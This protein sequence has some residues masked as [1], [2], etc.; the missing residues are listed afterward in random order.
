VAAATGRR[1]GCA[2]DYN[3]TRDRAH[4]VQ[5]G[6]T[7]DGRAC[8]TVVQCSRA[9]GIVANMSTG[10]SSRRSLGRNSGLCCRAGNGA[11]FG[12]G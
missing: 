5:G 12:R 8:S 1:D 11:K 4:G 2:R 7:H 3:V 9:R 10:Q 6:R